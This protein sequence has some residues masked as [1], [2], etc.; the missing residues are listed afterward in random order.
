M[1][2][3]NG[4]GLCVVPMLAWL[5]LCGCEITNTGDEVGLEETAWRL[6]SIVSV[7]G[8]VL[9]TPPSAEIYQ[10]EIVGQDSVEGLDECNTCFGRYELGSEGAISFG[11]ICTEVGCGIGYGSMLSHATTYELKSRQL[12]IRYSMHG[13]K[14]VLVH[15]VAPR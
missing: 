9:F 11:L 7:E 12:R 4:L 6:E 14:R 1:N 3:H 10:F 13:E 5:F 8:D 15:R 2:H